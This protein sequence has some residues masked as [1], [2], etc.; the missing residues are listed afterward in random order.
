MAMRVATMSPMTSTD[1]S[2]SV[3]EPSYLFRKL[4]LLLLLITAATLWIVL[5]F[6]DRTNFPLL[7]ST[8]F[9]DMSLGLIAGFGS[10]I[11]LQRRGGFVRFLTGIVLVIF[12]MILIRDLS[13]WVLGVGPIALDSKAAE[14]VNQIKFHRTLPDQIRSLKIDPLT[15]FNFRKMDW[16]DPIH[17][18]ISLLMTVM[19]LRAWGGAA[20]PA[21]SVIE[22]EPL[23]VSQLTPP[24][25]RWTRTASSSTSSN[26]RARVQ[27]PGG[28]LARMRPSPHSGR[29]T[30]SNNGI[31]SMVLKE[32]K[33]GNGQSVRSKRKRS[34][35]R[36]IDVALTGEH[37]CP[38]CL[39]PV[40]RNDSR[41]VKECE[42]CHTLHHADCW[43]IT[44]FC[45]VP[46]LN[47]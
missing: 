15:F 46:H 14:Q 8:S 45:Q 18:A 40:V 37:R 35:R 10:K 12:G 5:L 19:S 36:A 3:R 28:W 13:D 17:L 4:V 39:D 34:H 42:V 21:S 26:G 43:A 9:T 47:T 11:V 25:T 38:Y 31:R 20:S 22:V 6:K 44:G 23:S 41:G 7:L 24:R 32:A 1:P 33:K 16:A 27:L 29:G 30:R 2:S